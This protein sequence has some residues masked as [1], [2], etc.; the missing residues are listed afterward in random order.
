MSKLLQLLIAAGIVIACPGHVPR[1]T[2]QTQSRKALPQPASAV[3]QNPR[4]IPVE[5]P[6]LIFASVRINNSE[7]LRFILDS[8]S[9]W[10]ILDAGQAA[11]LGLK[12]EG[13][14]TVYGVGENALDFTF[15]RDVS[16]DISGVGLA[17]GTLAILPL[18][19][20]PYVGL[21][22]S[23]FFKKFVVEIDYAGQTVNLYDP[24]GFTYA[25]PGEVIPL[26]M[27]EEIPVVRASIATRTRG[28]MP[29]RLD[30]DTGA[31]QTILLARPF[32][33]SNKL[34]ESTEGMIGIGAGGL[35]GKTSYLI[36]RAKSVRLGRFVFEDW[37]TGFWQD[38]KG[39]GASDSRDGVVGNGL[40]KRFR[41]I[42]DYSRKQIILEP[43]ELFGVPFD[44][45]WCGFSVVTDGNDFRIDRVLRGTAAGDAGLQVGDVIL[46][47]D[48][49]PAEKLKLGE[50]RR[51]FR[52]DG[53]ERVLSVRR[54]DEVRQIRLQTTRI[55]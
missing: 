9:T 33:E 18:K 15:A 30:V 48:G 6:H 42:F 31:S 46:A 3:R 13:R 34:L 51:L 12:T 17:V 23:D 44:Y 1:G 8:A 14:R 43:T 2:Q 20:K 32:V 38:Q 40:L 4:R 26:E 21:I 25:G 45:D 19:G 11:A 28:P 24:A 37:L 16:L 7:P 49:A 53:R 41:V 36:G 27:R 39:A 5:I 54:N 52:Q 50:L 29:A 47:V 10:T 22:G 55:P 35:G